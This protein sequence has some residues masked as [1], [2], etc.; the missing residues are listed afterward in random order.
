MI[1]RCDDAD[2]ERVPDGLMRSI[3]EM[4]VQSADRPHGSFLSDG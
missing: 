1:D 2:E 4:D 3:A